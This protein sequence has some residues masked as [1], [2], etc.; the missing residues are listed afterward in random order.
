MDYSP[1]RTV[2]DMVEQLYC[3]LDWIKHSS[4]AEDFQNCVHLLRN[5]LAEGTD[6]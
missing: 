2:T 1:H 3:M 6:G 5:T 4:V